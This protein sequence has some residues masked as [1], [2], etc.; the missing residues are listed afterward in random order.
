MGLIVTNI[1]KIALCKNAVLKPNQNPSIPHTQKNE[2]NEKKSNHFRRNQ[3][4]RSTEV[5]N[6]VVMWMKRIISCLSIL[7]PCF[8]GMLVLWKNENMASIGTACDKPMSKLT[9]P[10]SKLR[11]DS[12]TRDLKV[13]GSLDLS[14]HN[15]FQLHSWHPG[16]NRSHWMQS[17]PSLLAYLFIPK[18]KWVRR[19]IW[20]VGML[21]SRSVLK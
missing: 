1:V 3:I 20:V 15:I 4:Y 5:S 18:I 14:F 21:P 10:F 11:P 9:L 19:E 7:L 16:I 2:T 6:N 12:T 13:E 17:L 8:Y